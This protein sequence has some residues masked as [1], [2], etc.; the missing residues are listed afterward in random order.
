MDCALKLNALVYDEI[1]F[2]RLGMQN[3]NELKLMLSVGVGTNKDDEKLKK[4]SVRIDGEKKEEYNFTVQ[5]SGFFT[6]TEGMSM[7]EDKLLQ[8]NA[9]AI[10][11]PYIRSEVSILTAQPGMDTVVLPPLNTVE[12]LNRLI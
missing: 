6:L 5:A 4:V 10:I 9:V 7:E 1:N 12:L 11:M 3:E 8:Q 2:T